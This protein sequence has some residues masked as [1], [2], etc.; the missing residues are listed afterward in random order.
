MATP[1]SLSLLPAAYPGDVWV[2]YNQSYALI[3]LQG[4]GASLGSKVD[5]G[6][7]LVGFFG[8]DDEVVDVRVEVGGD[9]VTVVY[10]R[11]R[12]SR[13]VC[14]EYSIHDNRGIPVEVSPEVMYVCVYIWLSVIWLSVFL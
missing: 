10:Y 7:P 13:E 1:T 2:K 11:G 4:G 12:A 5:S 3:Q 9:Q 8:A 14:G 6:L